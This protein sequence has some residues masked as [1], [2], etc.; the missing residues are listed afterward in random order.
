MNHPKVSILMLT[1]N[2]PEHVA[3]TLEG[4]RTTTLIRYELIVLDNG[5]GPETLAVLQQYRDGIDKFILS[6][7]NLLW[8]KG[9]NR[10]F[11]ESDPESHYV[12]LL[13]SDV[14]IRSPLWLAVLV[15]WA[16]W[17]PQTTV[18]AH[19]HSPAQ[20]CPGPRDIVSYGWVPFPARPDGWS[21]LIRREIYAKYRISEY[22]PWYWGGDEFFARAMRDGSRAGVLCNLHPYIH[23][24]G[25]AS[26]PEEARENPIFRSHR[27]PDVKLWYDGLQ[28]ETL[29][30]TVD[31][32]GEFIPGS[33][34]DY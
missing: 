1:H 24:V 13:N 33:G 26:W 3:R 8:A 29:N 21:C 20:P 23:H 9:N 32:A 17:M 16:E 4:I 14:E 6:P 7:E 30:F 25:H 28:T 19:S 31:A 10:A 11:D 18:P 15:E 12:L 5:S 34:I 2:A 27:T 22:F